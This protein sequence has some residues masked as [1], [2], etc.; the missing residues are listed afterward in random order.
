MYSKITARASARDAKSISSP[1]SI[2]RVPQ[3]LSAIAHGSCA[4]RSFYP[5]QVKLPVQILVVTSCDRSRP[6]CR[7]ADPPVRLILLRTGS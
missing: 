1:S 7:S 4:V 6:V 2:L 5:N 3:K